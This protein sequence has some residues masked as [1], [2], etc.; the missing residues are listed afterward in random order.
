MVAAAHSRRKRAADGG[1]AKGLAAGATNVVSAE[2]QQ[3]REANKS[4]RRPT[5]QGA[6]G[7]GG[8]E[9]GSTR[10]GWRECRSVEPNRT[11]RASEQAARRRRTRWNAAV[12]RTVHEKAPRGCRIEGSAVS[13]RWKKCPTRNSLPRNCAP[14]GSGTP[15]RSSTFRNC[16]WAFATKRT[17]CGRS[18][19]CAPYTQTRARARRTSGP[20]ASFACIACGKMKP[21]DAVYTLVGH[22]FIPV[23]RG[24]F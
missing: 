21:V 12:A 11:G 22:A 16:S 18:Q 20:R 5:Q 10:C 19:S 1:D 15:R 6:A 23:V 8:A 13:E 3:A 14:L 4:S 2:M 7:R 24:A 17:R 9:G